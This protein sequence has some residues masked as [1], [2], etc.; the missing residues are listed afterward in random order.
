[1]TEKIKLVQ[2][3]TRPA[4]VCTITDATTGTAINLTG[5]SI[6]LKFR[7]VGLDTL[8]ATIPG[9]VLDGAAGSV[10]FY[11]ASNPLM[12]EGEPGD[13]EGEI[14]IVFPDGQI[15]TVYQPLKFKVRGDF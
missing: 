5:C 6:V 13:Y 11:P 1:M 3:D 9:F 15:Q 14:E 10:V 4:I 7:E 12:L 8:Q 2:G